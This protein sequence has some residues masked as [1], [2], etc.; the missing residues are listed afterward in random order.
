MDIKLN[1]RLAAY[2][3]IDSL[4][5]NKFPKPDSSN[6]GDVLGVTGNGEYGLID[7]VTNESID[8]LFDGQITPAVSV[9]KD[10]IDTLFT[11]DQDVEIVS[12]EAI[13]SLFK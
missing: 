3:K 12:K 11:D 1:A 2:S 6:A 7:C 4:D 9:N 5:S 13:D 10:T 8:T